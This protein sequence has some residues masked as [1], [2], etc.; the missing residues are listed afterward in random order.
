V[1]GK[2]DIYS[3]PFLKSFPNVAFEMEGHST[4]KSEYFIVIKNDDKKTRGW[5]MGGG[6]WGGGT[7]LPMLVLEF[8]VISAKWMRLCPHQCS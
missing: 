4:L 6:G 2:A 3:N 7:H 5:G 1:F 8:G